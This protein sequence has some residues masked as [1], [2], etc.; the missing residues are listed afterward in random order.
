MNNKLYTLEELEEVFVKYEKG[1]KSALKSLIGKVFRTFNKEKIHKMFKDEYKKN[2]NKSYTE[3]Y[4]RFKLI[5]L[6]KFLESIDT[7]N[8]LLKL[9]LVTESI[10]PIIKLKR[11]TDK[12]ISNIKQLI[13]NDSII[14]PELELNR[15]QIILKQIIAHI[16]EEMDNFA[17]ELSTLIP[18]Y[19]DVI[20]TKKLMVFLTLAQN[21]CMTIQLT[22]H[23]KD[24]LKKYDIINPAKGI[25]VK[26]DATGNAFLYE[27]PHFRLFQRDLNDDTILQMYLLGDSSTIP[28]AYKHISDN[29]IKNDAQY[30]FD[31]FVDW[32]WKFA[33]DKNENRFVPDRKK[34]FCIEILQI[35]SLASTG[36]THLKGKFPI[37]QPKRAWTRFKTANASA[38]KRFK[39][40]SA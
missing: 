40:T 20:N 9:F 33:H 30:H 19:F 23:Q 16:V 3:R 6:S 5:L 24:L 7:T 2:T 32:L 10:I 1:D 25:P 4:T 39:K 11:D 21:A 13:K 15:L 14:L 29:L 8:P 22:E 17:L 35:V 31:F 28:N 12:M 37:D 27:D 34:S 26:F 18:K 36:T 38:Q